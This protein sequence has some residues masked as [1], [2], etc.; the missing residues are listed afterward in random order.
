[1]KN[2]SPELEKELLELLE[3]HRSVQRYGARASN[4]AANMDVVRRISLI[5]DEVRLFAI[6]LAQ[7]TV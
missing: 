6:Q 3:A 7:L 1:M 4:H 5:Q 2:P